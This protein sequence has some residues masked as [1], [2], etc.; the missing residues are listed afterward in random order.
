MEMMKNPADCDQQRVWS[1]LEALTSGPSRVL[2]EQLRLIL[3]PT[4]ATKLQGDYRTGKRINMK[5]VIG[6]IASQF[7]KD[8]IWMRR[9]KPNKRRYQVILAIDDSRSMSESGCGPVAL[10][11]LTTICK[12]MSLLE[13]GEM[14]VVRALPGRLR[15]SL[16]GHTAI[17]VSFGEMGKVKL[18]HE[19][20]QPFST[21]SGA[22][23]VAG[24]TF[25][26]DN[27]IN[28]EPVLELLQYLHAVMESAAHRLDGANDKNDLQ[29]L[30]I[31][32]ADGRFHEKEK[33]RR[34]IRNAFGAH[35][36][37]AFVV[38]DSS[39]NSVLDMQSVTFSGGAPTFRSYMDSFPFP[40]YTVVQDVASL[41][42]TLSDLMRQW[43]E[44]SLAS[45]Y[46]S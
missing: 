6:Y 25:Q 4:L 15:Y 40:F 27:K 9:T 22:R 43:F 29:Q 2:A 31:I 24:F 33:L 32:L 39:R 45:T 18:L 30:V 35:Q 36:M 41:P 14:G 26:Q 16:D 10:E 7:R 3:E 38:L 37:L 12:A 19:L 34:C 1:Q 46:N 42:R 44:L 8:K 5:K 11:A 28:D 17:Q 21:E 23:L 20:E 13:V